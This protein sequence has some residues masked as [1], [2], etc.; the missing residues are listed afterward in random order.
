MPLR[1]FGGRVSEKLASRVGHLSSVNLTEKDSS[2][3]ASL[4]IGINEIA[5][6]RRK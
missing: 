5:D 4:V 3:F 6:P 2:Y 1:H